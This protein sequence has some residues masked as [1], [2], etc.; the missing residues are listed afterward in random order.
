LPFF[1]HS[2]FH[3]NRRPSDLCA[4]AIPISD[5]FTVVQ[6]R[7]LPMFAFARIKG[8]PVDVMVMRDEEDTESA[9]LIMDTFDEEYINAAL[10]R[11]PEECKLRFTALREINSGEVV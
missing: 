8:A 9:V 3:C 6:T 5:R 10:T 1:R 4:E 11:T 7:A 2:I